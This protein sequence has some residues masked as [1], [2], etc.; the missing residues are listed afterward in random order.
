[1][2]IKKVKVVDDAIIYWDVDD[3]EC[4]DDELEDWDIQFEGQK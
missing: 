4:E 2:K 3:C 1:M